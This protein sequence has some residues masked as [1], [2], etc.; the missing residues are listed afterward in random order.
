MTIGDLE[1]IKLE[2]RRTG[3]V[4]LGL[5]M[6]DRWG[7]KDAESARKREEDFARFDE[8]LRTLRAELAKKID[9]CRKNDATVLDMWAKAHIELLEAFIAHKEREGDFEKYRTSL[10]V[11][12]KEIDEWQAFARGEI[13]DVDQNYFYVSY[14]KERF[15]ALFGIEM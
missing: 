1:K 6:E 8:Q 4:L 7:A 14:D 10:Y 3:G 2:I 12:R 13:D 5:D 15:K 11:A 9:Y